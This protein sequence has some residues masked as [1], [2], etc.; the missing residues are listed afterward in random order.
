[1]SSFS[2]SNMH[3]YPGINLQGYLLGAMKFS[4]N[5]LI[6][7][8]YFTKRTWTQHNLQKKNDVKIWHKTSLNRPDVAVYIK[9]SIW[10][11]EAG[12]FL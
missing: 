7:T 10:E 8:F 2:Y 4:W 6:L 11:A 1:M 9:L 5:N 12:R 3:E